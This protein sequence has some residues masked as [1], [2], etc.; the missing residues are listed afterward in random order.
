MKKGNTAP[1]FT[2]NEDCMAPG[3]E[4]ANAPQKLS[5]IDSNLLNRERKI[6]LR[7]NSADYNASPVEY[8]GRQLPFKFI[9]RLGYNEIFLD[10]SI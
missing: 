3:Y 8:C 10:A 9:I 6:I 4:P 5:D 2:F 1:N 7:P